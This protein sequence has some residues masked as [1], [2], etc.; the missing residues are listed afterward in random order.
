MFAYN[1][2]KNLR[3]SLTNVQSNVDEHLDCVYLL[4]NGCT[5]DTVTLAQKLK[6]ELAFEQL[7]IKEIAL[8]DKCNAWNHYVHEI[9]VDADCHFFVDADVVFSDKCFPQLHK[10]LKEA[11]PTP[12]IVAGYP[13]SGRNLAFYQMLVEK[14]SCFFG[15][16]YG[17]SQQYIDMVRSKSFYLPVGLNWIDSFLTKAANTDIQF[18]KENLPN[19]VIYLKNVGF[20]FESLSPFRL[21]DIKLYKNRIA[22]YELGKI[23]EVYLDAIGVENWPKN[24]SEIN[25]DIL[26][27]FDAKTRELGFFLKTLVK[28]RLKKLIAKDTR[29]MFRNLS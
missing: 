26:N 3:T 19:K 27:N 10:A 4:A 13:L 8:G 20:Q 12:N 29:E 18:L 15:N 25:K 14:R 7:Q 23:Q 28:H 6:R 2:E 21:A 22:R 9:K 17:A 1:E 11:T 16:L 5:D 24:M